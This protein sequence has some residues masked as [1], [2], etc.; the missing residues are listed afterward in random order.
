MEH[1]RDRWVRSA[2]VLMLLAA[3]DD[4]VSPARG[5]ELATRTQAT[6]AP[7]E[8]VVSEGAEHGLDDPGRAKQNRDA[9]RRAT[10]DA[11]NRA[12]RFVR[13]SL[14]RATPAPAP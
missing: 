3:D 1:V 6:G 7:V 9:N 11:R 12:R 4:E 2:P 5:Q 8:L 14:E 13:V 10:A